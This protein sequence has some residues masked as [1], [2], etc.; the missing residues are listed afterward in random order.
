MLDISLSSFCALFR[1]SFQ[2]PIGR[3]SRYT[4]SPDFEMQLLNSNYMT[5]INLDICLYKQTIHYLI[6]YS[7]L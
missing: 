6:I 3:A 1:V 2:S 5:A 4:H 7:I